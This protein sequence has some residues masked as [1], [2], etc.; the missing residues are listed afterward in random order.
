VLFDQPARDDVPVWLRGCW[1]R[2]WIQFAEGARHETEHVFWLQTASAMADVRVPV[3]RPSFD[4]CTSVHHC[5]AEQLDSLAA[6]NASTGFTVAD[7]VRR[8]PDGTGRCTA[9]WFTYG[10]GV[11]FQPQCTFPEPGLLEVSADGTVMIE[12]APSGAYVEEWRLVPGSRE[13]LAHVRYGD[14]RE[15]FTAGR[16]TIDVRDRAVAVTEGRPFT[17]DSLDCEFSVAIAGD[18][19]RSRIVVSTLPWREGAML[20]DVA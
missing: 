18:D 19:G 5:S 15:R 10:H 7:D 13:G 1:R 17:A 2:A 8:G 6:A 16:I 4:G 20:D 11:N 9:Q 3:D 14:G 12:R